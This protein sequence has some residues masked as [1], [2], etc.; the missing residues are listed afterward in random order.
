MINAVPYWL[1]FPANSQG[2]VALR[3]PPSSSTE[4]EVPMASDRPPLQL[5]STLSSAHLSAALQQAIT[6]GALTPQ[7]FIRGRV[8]GLH[9][10]L[11]HD[12]QGQGNPPKPVFYGRLEPFDGGTVLRGHYRLSWRNRCLLAVGFCGLLVACSL[13]L[14]DILQG[15]GVDDGINVLAMAV[16]WGWMALQSATVHREDKAHLQTLLQ[17]VLADPEPCPASAAGDLDRVHNSQA[18][19]G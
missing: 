16:I 3:V 4:L 12:R 1:G 9:I 13:T 19:G 10:V 2:T 5:T 11:S 8:Q 17:R 7:G 14:H 15:R 6:P 18:I